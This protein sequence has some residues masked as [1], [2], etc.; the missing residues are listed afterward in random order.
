[1]ISKFLNASTFDG[2]NPYRVTKG[3]FDWE[4]IEPDNPWSYIGYWGDHQIIYLL[5]FLEFYQK[6]EPNAFDSLFNRDFF[7]YA[8]VPYRIKSYADITKDPKNTIEFDEHADRNIRK[9]IELKGADGALLTNPN[10]DIHRVNFIEKILATVL[11]KVSNFVPEGGIWMNT[12]R[13]E[14]NDANNALVGNGVSMV[15]LYYL[16]RFLAFFEQV[17]VE[18]NIQEIDVSEEIAGFFDRLN[19]ALSE[20]KI[21]LESSISDKTRKAITDALGQAGSDFRNQVYTHGFSGKKRAL[22]LKEIH[23]FSEL[24]RSYLVQSITANRRSDSLYHA[25]N[26]LSYSSEGIQ[27]EHLSEMLEGQV[28]VLSSQ[29]LKPKEA[30]QVLQALRKSALYREDQNSYIL[31]PNKALPG[32]LDKNTIP[33][34]LLNESTL[35]KK[36]VSDGDL[37]IVQKDVLGGYHFNGNFKNARDVKDALDSL[38]HTPYAALAKADEAKVLD[39]FERIFNHKAFTGRS[40]T[41]YGYEGLG[42]IYWHMVSKLYLAVE[43]VCSSSHEGNY[44]PKTFAELAHYFDEV[45]A[46]IGVHKAPELYGAFP[47]D[48]YSHT[49]YH[50]GAQQPGMTGQVKEDI[51]VRLGELG[52]TI[53]QGCLQFNPGLLKKEEFLSQETIFEYVDIHQEKQQLLMPANALGFTICQVPVV[54]QI[55]E[56]NRLE[57][58]MSDGTVQSTPQTALDK[59]LSHE[60]FNRT[61]NVDLL[62][63]TLTENQLR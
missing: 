35:L 32:F 30:L 53:K 57:A 47:T 10:G 7:V 46:G 42:S 40:G 55:G 15:T 48:P 17:T 25:Y 29:F 58:K 23:A 6:I 36:L 41:F 11:S 39:I 44:A 34:Q 31:Y 38:A 33:E 27:I 50:R 21:V 52:V 63:I 1:M 62:T 20:H 43:E 2:Y 19:A 61:G 59:S 60:V 12:Q 24:T 18:S 28:A 45:G 49:P 54:Y 3:G 14:W 37:H 51:L 5:K 13:P 4:T 8:H 16:R 56:Q 9:Q 26:L 22:R